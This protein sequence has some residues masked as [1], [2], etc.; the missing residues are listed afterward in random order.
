MQTALLKKYSAKDQRD[1]NLVRLHIQAVTLS[2]VSTPE[3][4]YIK[5]EAL[6]GQRQP[7]QTIRKNWPRQQVPTKHQ[8]HL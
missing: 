5:W 4:K 7:N 2:D 6:N 3:G 8:L 1:I